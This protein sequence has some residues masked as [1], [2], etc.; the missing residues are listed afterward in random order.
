M[1]K[2]SKEFYTELLKDYPDL[3][4]KE[5]FHYFVTFFKGLW[6]EPGMIDSWENPED[7]G[8]GTLASGFIPGVVKF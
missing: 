4:S 6:V 8:K 5:K 2:K 7:F 3:F 1:H